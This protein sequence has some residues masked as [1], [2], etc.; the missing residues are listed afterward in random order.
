MRATKADT[1]LN[2][3][4]AR[5]VICEG[6]KFLQC[7]A[8]AGGKPVRQLVC[9]KLSTIL[10]VRLASY[11]IRNQS[12]R[13]EAR[14]LHRQKLH[15]QN[16]LEVRARVLAPDPHH[17]TA[18]GNARQSSVGRCGQPIPV[19]A[20]INDGFRVLRDGLEEV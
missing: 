16:P 7:R 5:S 11:A 17:A 12:V 20:D 1:L 8:M 6:T 13:A 18:A 19:L 14:A 10:C 2:A 3:L 4:P 9:V 15:R